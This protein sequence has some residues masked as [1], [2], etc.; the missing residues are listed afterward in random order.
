MTGLLRSDCFKP[1]AVILPPLSAG[2]SSASA[3]RQCSLDAGLFFRLAQRPEQFIRLEPAELSKSPT[4][5]TRRTGCVDW[6]ASVV[7]AGDLEN[8]RFH[9]AIGPSFLI[10]GVLFGS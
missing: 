7:L 3:V 2:G 1:L 5:C 9:D 8:P 6:D 4:E 10:L